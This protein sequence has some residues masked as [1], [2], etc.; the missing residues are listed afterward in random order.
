[1]DSIEADEFWRKETN[2]KKVQDHESATYGW[3]EGEQRQQNQSSRRNSAMGKA[4]AWGEGTEVPWARVLQLAEEFGEENR[5]LYS[6]DQDLWV[7]RS[8][9]RWEW[10]QA[11]SRVKAGVT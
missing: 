8:D 9:G 7:E 4:R 11:S 10:S 1:M 2:G 6:W 5:N 3:T